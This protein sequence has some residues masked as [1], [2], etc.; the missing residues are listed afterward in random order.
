MCGDVGR[1]CQ[2]CDRASTAT[3]AR[4][5]DTDV[6]CLFVLSVAPVVVLSTH[7]SDKMSS[8]SNLGTFIARAVDGMI[9]VASMDHVESEYATHA[10]KILRSLKPTSPAR[11]TIEAG[12]CFFQYVEHRQIDRQRV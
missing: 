6:L 7:N 9:L 4:I 1:R 5:A 11:C 12:P 8:V 10:K 3:F 2:H